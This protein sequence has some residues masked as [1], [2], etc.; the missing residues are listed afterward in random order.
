MTY[1]DGKIYKLLDHT[2][3]NIYIGSTQQ[4]LERRRQ[5][6]IYDSWNYGKIQVGKD[7][8]RVIKYSS[9]DI[10]INKH[11]D[12]YLLEA[13][14]CENKL[15]LRMKEQEWIDKLD[16]VNRQRAYRT[17]EQAEEQSIKCWEARAK[18][19]EWKEYKRKLY[20]Y[21]STWGESRTRPYSTNLLKIDPNLF[22]Y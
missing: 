14:P 2:T 6:H 3:G 22:N 8:N 18:K 13:Y 12:I 20:A 7:R 5:K 17:K 4:T 19:P 21:Q 1:K 9:H 16:C 15:E 11:W 10:I